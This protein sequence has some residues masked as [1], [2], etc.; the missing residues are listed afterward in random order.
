MK[1][2]KMTTT[3]FLV[4]LNVCLSVEQAAELCLKGVR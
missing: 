2:H 1:C 3:I 4:S